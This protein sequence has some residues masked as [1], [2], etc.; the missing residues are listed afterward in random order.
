MNLKTVLAILA[1]VF[2]L[3]AA[4]AASATVVTFDDLPDNGVVADGYGGVIWGGNWGY[5]KD[6]LPPY[7]AASGDTVAYSDL[8]LGC[9]AP[10]DT[11]FYFAAPVIFDGAFFSGYGTAFDAAPITFGLYNGGVLVHTSDA[12]E[13]GQVPQFLA[14]G[15]AGLVDEVRV[16]GSR[17]LF[18]MDDVTYTGA[19][20]PAAWALMIAGFGLA[21]GAL[22]RRRA[23]RVSAASPGNRS[24]SAT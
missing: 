19:P 5:Y 8:N 10:D 24:S 16:N 3:G 15:Y 21:G 9:C 22:R 17:D 4:T 7:T 11:N 1:A 20:E 14:S 18:V 6:P 23:V 13:A 2:S 12:L